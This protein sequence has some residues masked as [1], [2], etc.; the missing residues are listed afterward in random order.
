MC[1]SPSCGAQNALAPNTNRTFELIEKL[2]AD[3]A[4]V[5][6]DTVMHVGGDEV[7]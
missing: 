2:L 1:P 5:T 7:Q 6:T 3:V 4:A